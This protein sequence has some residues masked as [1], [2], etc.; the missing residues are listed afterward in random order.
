MG[1]GVRG[2]SAG[3]AMLELSASA[4]KR[5]PAVSPTLPR[6]VPPPRPTAPVTPS[7][8]AVGTAPA[9]PRGSPRTLAARARER[10]ARSGRRSKYSSNKRV[11]SSQT[12]ASGG[13]EEGGVGLGGQRWRGLAGQP[14]VHAACAMRALALSPAAGSREPGPSRPPGSPPPRPVACRS[15]RAH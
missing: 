3:H 4:V 14:G 8:A 2:R 9:A 10:R 1:G 11:E 12:C 7:V 5:R 13:R 15:H 6:N